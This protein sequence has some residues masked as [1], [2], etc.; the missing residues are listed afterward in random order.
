QDFTKKISAPAEKG[1]PLGAVII[2]VND[3]PIYEYHYLLDHDIQESNR[4]VL[5]RFIQENPRILLLYGVFLVLLLVFIPSFI[6]A[7]LPRRRRR[8][9]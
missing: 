9:R 6:L 7:H 4:S 5:L 8:H 3:Q 1:K 2:H